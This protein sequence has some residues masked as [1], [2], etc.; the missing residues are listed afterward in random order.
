MQ[1][2]Y[3]KANIICYLL[4]IEPVRKQS[5]VCRIGIL[6]VPFCQFQ[7]FYQIFI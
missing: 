6:L 1:R 4:S 2:D 5:I 3:L 7:M